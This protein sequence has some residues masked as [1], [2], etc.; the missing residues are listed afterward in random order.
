MK[1]YSL[2]SLKVENVRILVKKTI[3]FVRWVGSMKWGWALGVK[4]IMEYIFT[5]QVSLFDS[6]ISRLGVSPKYSLLLC[7]FRLTRATA[8]RPKYARAL[9]I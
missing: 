8:Y 7:A 2:F 5:T 1:L 9:K 3:V 4:V 6:E